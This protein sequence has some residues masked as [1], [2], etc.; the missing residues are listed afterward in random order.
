MP[1]KPPYVLGFVGENAN[2]ILRWGTEIILAAFEKYGMSHQLIDLQNPE[3]V[4]H[5]NASLSIA[6]PT[7]CFSFQSIGTDI[8]VDHHCNIWSRLEVPFL[9]H[10][11]DNPYHCPRLHRAESPFIYRLFGAEDLRQTYVRYFKGRGY[12]ALLDCGYPANPLMD[13]TAWAQRTHNL[14][15]VKTGV[16]ASALRK[17]WASFPA[18]IREILEEVREQAIQ[19]SN[20]TIA[21]LCEQSFRN[22]NIDWG[23]RIEFFFSVCSM[24][25]FY[26]R[27]LQAEKMVRALLPH[28]ALIVGNWSHLDCSGARAR[29][30]DPIPA[31]ELDALYADSRVLL[32]TLPTTRYG[33]HERILA[34]FYAK[35]SVISDST[36]YLDER[37]KGFP[38]FTS[39][40]IH[41]ENFPEALAQS[42][43]ANLQDAEGDEKRRISAAEVEVQFS[44]ETFVRG[45]VDCLA[46]EH[47]RHMHEPWGLPT[48]VPATA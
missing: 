44:T 7:L 26:V 1:I 39:V 19:G 40:K 13:R 27:A 28:D 46:L 45:L 34:G 15:Y 24:V 9:T 38:S 29:I 5:L 16:D 20:E 47:Y 32:N 48:A 33:L 12:A 3:W 43:Q 2:G 30:V 41:E 10:N 21:D 31:T 37:L 18:K 14:V 17:K 42:I 36:P 23:E 11:N 25:D 22:R 6:K 35:A 8:Q 4:Q